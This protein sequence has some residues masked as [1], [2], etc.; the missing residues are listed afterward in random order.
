MRYDAFISYSHEA[1]STFAKAFQKG[2]EQLAKPWNKKRALYVFR[3]E[4]D[5]SINPQLLETI[6]QVLDQSKFF[7]LLASPRAAS[8]KWVKEEVEHWLTERHGRS[9]LIILT[10]GELVWNDSDHDFDWERTNALPPCLRGRFDGEPLWVDFRVIKQ[11]PDLSLK[12]EAFLDAVA[13]VAAELHGRSKRDLVGEDVRQ[14][15]K[16]VRAKRMVVVAGSVLTAGV[17]YFYYSAS[18][19]R[20]FAEQ[21][22]ITVLARRL[23][24]DSSKVVEDQARMVDLSL[25]LAVE[26]IRRQP[27][28]ETDAALRRSLALY[29]KSVPYDA[30]A[31]HN[32]AFS[33]DSQVAA[34]ARKDGVDVIE[35]PSGTIRTRL[36]QSTK[37][38]AIAVSAKEHLASAGGDGVVRVF[39]MTSGNFI[40]ELHAGTPVQDL[41]FSVD[42][43]E[44]AVSVGKSVHIFDTEDWKSAAQL[45][46]AENVHIAFDR[47]GQLWA[48]GDEAATVFSKAKNGWHRKAIKL[49]SVGPE[50]ATTVVSSDGHLIASCGHMA[51]LDKNCRIF[52]VSDGARISILVHPDLVQSLV[53]SPDKRYVATTSR[54]QVI[55]VFE[56][57]SGKPVSYVPES[58]STTVLFSRDSRFMAITNENGS[59]IYE[60]FSSVVVRSAPGRLMSATFSGDAR[61]VAHGGKVEAFE[62]ASGRQLL[63][64]ELALNG[65][66]VGL[67]SDGHLL[68]TG[69]PTQIVDLQ[70]GKLID[71]ATGENT[72]SSGPG[73][74][75]M[76]FAFN[77]DARYL[78][79][80]SGGHV[81]LQDLTAHTQVFDHPVAQLRAVSLSGDGKLL[82]A[83][84]QTGALL[85]SSF[86]GKQLA[87]LR[88]EGLVHAVAL[89]RD[90]RYM[91]S[92][93]VDH[94]VQLYDIVQVKKLPSLNHEQTVYAISFSPDGRYIATGGLD[95]TARIFEL[96]SSSEVARLYHD[97][98]VMAIVFA[99]DSK[100]VLT[101]TGWGTQEQDDA[102]PAGLT[103]H[104]FAVSRNAL[105]TNDLIEEA[106]SRLN[107]NL[108][109][110]EWKQHVGDEPW[111]KTCPNLP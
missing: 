16:F 56:T 100:Y 110:E 12:Q 25:L 92:G 103:E 6:F 101:A 34:L 23:A 31:A 65:R 72:Q 107:R 99:P 75:V 66:S 80:G 77:S 81:E 42:G 105:Q 24:S 62:V 61:Y 109:P 39:D 7:L 106:C 87:C 93:G 104:F 36:A 98:P 68:A 95:K 40:R 73:G 4:T 55:R 53:F 5:L 59:R 84:T 50:H 14:H 64:P 13:T 3:D 15:Q 41:E 108:T 28:F 32:I 102:Q 19:Q 18:Q 26:S 22:R 71:S 76:G 67:S 35:L 89:S 91:A 46:I 51:S 8:S 10:T 52:N 82:A 9:L 83:A 111:R 21:R 94:Q 27:M 37:P 69:K 54:D 17:M 78:A 57:K 85:F 90:G 97:A 96:A 30:S 43:D 58:P 44:L 63:P 49:P 33:P 2:L 88:H 1:D 47:E 29:P 60:L 20:H 11:L 86:E 70:V 45:N 38:D 48:V 79:V 74:L